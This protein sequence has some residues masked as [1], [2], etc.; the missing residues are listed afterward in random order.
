MLKE[1]EDLGALD[2]LRNLYPGYD[3]EDFLD[4]YYFEDFL[5]TNI[6]EAA[7]YLKHAKNKLDVVEEDLTEAKAKDSSKLSR[8]YEEIKELADEYGPEYF[9][10]MPFTAYD[11]DPTSIEYQYPEFFRVVKAFF[12]EMDLLDDSTKEEYIDANG[13]DISIGEVTLNNPDV[14]DY[15]W[16]LEDQLSVT[17]PS[18][19]RHDWDVLMRTC[20]KLA[21]GKGTQI[22]KEYKTGYNSPL[23]EPEEVEESL[24]EAKGVLAPGQKF[25]NAA[26]TVIEIVEPNVYGEPQFNIIHDGRIDDIRRTSDYKTLARILDSNGYQPV[27]DES[28]K[29]EVGVTQEGDLEDKYSVIYNIGGRNNFNVRVSSQ[30][31]P[32]EPRTFRASRWTHDYNS[33]QDVLD[34]IEN[35]KELL[36]VM[37]ELEAKGI[38]NESK[39]NESLEEDT[40]I[41]KV[42]DEDNADRWFNSIT[43]IGGKNN[44]EI[45]T[46]A[47]D[48]K[49]QSKS[50][51][52]SRW[53]HNYKNVQEV[54]DDIENLQA[55]KARMLELEDKGFINSELEESL[56][57]SKLNESALD[58]A[59]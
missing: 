27:Y 21:K 46:D 22:E 29:E 17:S 36:K 31:D 10:Q 57:E 11:N 9:T 40:S 39:V 14:L 33:E 8:E 6:E 7:K 35:L 23:D 32:D 3:D 15:L 13:G 26:G 2:S 56:D 34:D 54:E 38:H 44:F 55:L 16:D 30:W 12:K 5:P 59:K 37:Q 42:G 52:A 53:S 28:L 48:S 4:T 24:N 45:S 25:K 1:L 49:G 50:Y 41:Q 20:E 58:T 51:T 43:Y 18:D 19:F 47:Y